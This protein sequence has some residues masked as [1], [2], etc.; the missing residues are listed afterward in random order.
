MKNLLHRRCVLVAATLVCGTAM[1][2][3]AQTSPDASSLPAITVPVTDRATADAWWKRYGI[4]P[5]QGGFVLAHP[6]TKPWSGRSLV[7][8][9]T[10]LEQANELDIRHI[11]AKTPLLINAAA[12]RADLP[13]LRMVLEKDYS[14]WETATEKGWDWNAWF[15]QWD[16]MLA[17]HGEHAIPDGQAFAP[18]F[19]YEDFQI[20]SHSGPHIPSRYGKIIHSDSALL[21]RKPSSI[22]TR[23][24]TTDGAWH[25]LAARDPAQQPHA[26]ERWTGTMLQATSYMVYPSSF[27]TAKNVVCGDDTI[28]ATPFW[29]PYAHDRA[30]S[31]L[32]QSVASLSGGKKGLAI[33]HTLAPGIGYLRL[34]SFADAGDEALAKLLPTLPESAGHEKELIVDLR[35]NDGGNAPI[36]LLSRW[37]PIEKISGQLTQIGKRSCLYPG[38]WFNLGQMLALRVKPPVT[39]G[40]REM[41]DV[42]MRGLSAPPSTAC[43]VSFKTTSG[44][45]RYTDHQFVRHWQGPYPRLL[46]L[47]DDECGSD[48][49]YM[50]WMLAQL[51]GTVI[52]GENTFGVTGFTQPGF[53][54]LPHTRIVFQLATSRTDSYGD[55]R[56]ENGYGLDV[57]VVL[58]VQ[59]DWSKHSLLA[60]AEKLIAPA[61]HES[62]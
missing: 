6:W 19:A 28:A 7:V 13:I 38:L 45:W 61:Q 33:Y 59:T 39:P 3:S 37:I 32:A 9:P 27:G 1:A 4:T 14:G 31:P 10:W 24:Q 15:E 17:T 26:V 21:A 58:P 44:T 51:P 20:D 50:T 43:P 57:D 49:E 30:K 35:G 12:L 29:S 22:C 62:L 23:L 5:P 54:L 16:A 2:A 41:M 48:C 36:K 46:V 47:V 52:A 60:L 55:G 18:W 56:S 11:R 34:A 40:F 42:Y 8:P 25:H 53:L